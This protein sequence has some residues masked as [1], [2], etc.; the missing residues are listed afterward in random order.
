MDKDGDNGKGRDWWRGKTN[1]I[2]VYACKVVKKGR[3]YE[4]GATAAIRMNAD[5]I[6]CAQRVNMKEW[7]VT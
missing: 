2:V 1:E 6:V 5:L 3:T 7:E 4:W